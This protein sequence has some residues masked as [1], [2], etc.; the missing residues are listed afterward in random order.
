MAS[1]PRKYFTFNLCRWVKRKQLLLN[2]NN[3]DELEVTTWLPRVCSRPTDI[4]PLDNTLSRLMI[5]WLGNQWIWKTDDTVTQQ[6]VN[7]EDWWYS[8]S[9]ISESGRLMIQ[10]L[11]NQRIW[12]ADDTVTQQSANLE[13]WWYSDSAISESERSSFELHQQPYDNLSSIKK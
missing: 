5:Q 4:H 6:S 1:K 10:W 12:K 7:V 2:G 9:A 3:L 8:D 13:G 11:S